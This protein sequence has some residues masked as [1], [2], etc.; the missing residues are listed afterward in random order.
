MTQKWRLKKITLILA[1]A[2]L[3]PLFAFCGK[4]SGGEPEAPPTPDAGFAE[5]A[6]Y[7]ERPAA[8]PAETPG[9]ES[10]GDI[11]F[12][13]TAWID[14]TGVF[15]R[16][17]PSAGAAKLSVLT[18]GQE[19]LLMNAEDGWGYV[20]INGTAGYVSMQFIKVDDENTVT[21]PVP[22]SDGDTLAVPTPAA[23]APAE[24]S[25]TVGS[26]P[27]WIN[28]DG[29]NFRKSPSRD[30]EIIRKL[31]G[32]Q[33]ILL[34]GG[35]EEWSYIS[36]NGTE[37]YVS[38]EFVSYETAAAPPVP[39]QKPTVFNQDA[40]SY[41][42]AIDPGHQAKGNSENEPIGPGSSQTKPKVASGTAGVSTK[43]P[44]YKLTL[45]VSL[46]LRDEL[47]A[48]GYRV[49]M[50]RETHEV[51]ISNK[52][53]AV[54]ATGADADIFIRLHADGST[55][56]GINGI[57]ALCPTGKNPY[58]PHLYAQSRLLSDYIL[59]STVSAT[60]AFNRGVLEVDSM[61]GINWATM[62]VTII[63]MGLMTNPEEDRLMQTPEYQQ[64]LVTG[65]ADGVDKYFSQ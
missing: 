5:E 10:A 1:A 33:N 64:K 15:F 42:I 8:R 25:G 46:K 13:A 17:E 59:T 53:R 9:A 50:I 32:G 4:D 3:V 39:T 14:G 27:A 40:G 23:P 28:T 62:P 35:N 24:G 49:Y 12:P 65:I 47:L 41:M 37:G 63:E 51:N 2:A 19:V 45:E 20:L 21:A 18:D 52:E 56:I 44:E 29:V 36:V 11:R 43:V 22:V 54:M 48:R 26:E 61:S 38:R 55:N 16:A 57:L 31:N 30:A 34:L 7:T 60:G 58:I 6:V